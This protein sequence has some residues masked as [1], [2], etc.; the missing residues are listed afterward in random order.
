M[1]RITKLKRRY[2]NK[3]IAHNYDNE[4]FGHFVGRTFDRLEKRAIKQIL[5]YVR[6]AVES[7]NVL[8]LPCG[9]GRITELLLEGGLNVVGADVSEEM[10]AIGRQ[11]CARFSSRIVFQQ[12]DIHNLTLPEHG[13]DLVT[14]IRLLHHF[15]IVDRELILKQLATLTSRFLLINVSYSSPFYRL[16]RRCKKVLRFGVPKN[17]STWS[18]IQRETAAAGLTIVTRLFVMPF[19]S[20]DLLLLLSRK[21]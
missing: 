10:L 2:Q 3:A 21:Q 4:R 12:Q 17:S 15:G 20:E 14:C 9:T 8:D 11:R 18:E 13:F 19:V 6:N 5:R 16:R 1:N 7:P